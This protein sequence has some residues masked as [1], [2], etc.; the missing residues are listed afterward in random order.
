MTVDKKSPLK[1]TIA[2]V[3][4]SPRFVCDNGTPFAELES[5]LFGEMADAVFCVLS[6]HRDYRSV[7]RVDRADQVLICQQNVNDGLIRL[8]HGHRHELG[9]GRVIWRH[10]GLPIRSSIG[11]LLRDHPDTRTYFS[12]PIW[13]RAEVPKV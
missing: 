7:Q 4:V 1:I 9:D 3:R 11:P 5:R 8:F 2:G 10:P 13:T 6:Q 12:F